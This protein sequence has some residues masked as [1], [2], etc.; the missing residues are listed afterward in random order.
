MKIQFLVRLRT[1]G[2]P[3]P[4]ESGV[5][6]T[7]PRIT[8]L[9]RSAPKIWTFTT[10]KGRQEKSFWSEPF[11]SLRSQVR[12][13]LVRLSSSVS[14]APAGQVWFPAIYNR[15]CLNCRRTCQGQNRYYNSLRQFWPY[16]SPDTKLIRG[17]LDTPPRMFWLQDCRV[18]TPLF[19]SPHAPASILR[20]ASQGTDS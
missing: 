11:Q 19:S 5:L 12:C 20:Y 9:I 6:Y 15:E 10:L 16:Y 8:H 14:P 3:L 18:C 4:A 7:L 1:R 13:W 17:T 2:Y